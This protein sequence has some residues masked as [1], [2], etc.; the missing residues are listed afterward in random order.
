M[1]SRHSATASST[2]A[3]TCPAW[4]ARRRPYDAD[5]SRV[6]AVTALIGRIADAMAAE[7][8]RPGLHP[9][10]GTWIET[11]E[12]RRAV[13]EALPES[14][15]GFLPDTG[16]LAWSGSDVGTFTYESAVASARWMRAR[17]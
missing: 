15:L 4:H 16:H 12:E 8:V 13:L 17:S 10:I 14:R 3:S 11:E 6:E 9:H 2:W 5:P 7:G 1:L